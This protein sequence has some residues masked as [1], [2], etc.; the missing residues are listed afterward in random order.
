MVDEQMVCPGGLSPKNSHHFVQMS[1][2]ISNRDC[3]AAQFYSVSVYV[4]VT[5]LQLNGLILSNHVALKNNMMLIEPAQIT[6]ILIV[7]SF[8]E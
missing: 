4:I 1:I 7:E 8:A 6:R 5:L 3:L 2:Y